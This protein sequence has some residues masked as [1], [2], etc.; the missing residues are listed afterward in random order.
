MFHL[1]Q[2]ERRRGGRKDAP[3]RR[4]QLQLVR[5]RQRPGVLRGWRDG[6][7]F[8]GKS[9][10][11]TSVYQICD[12]AGAI[13]GRLSSNQIRSKLDQP[14]AIQSFGAV[15]HG[16]KSLQRAISC[17]SSYIEMIDAFYI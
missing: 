4:Q 5:Q 12:R 6:A 8:G 2:R 9:K 15:H 16:E 1:R 14:P 7:W 13:Q 11:G 3:T 17:S 10:T